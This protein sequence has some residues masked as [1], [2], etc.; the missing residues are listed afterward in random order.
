MASHHYAVILTFVPWLLVSALGPS[1]FLASLAHCLT[2]GTF[3]DRGH[4][5]ASC[6][7]K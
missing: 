7:W 6:D 5:F 4:V 2:Q 1:V 3:T